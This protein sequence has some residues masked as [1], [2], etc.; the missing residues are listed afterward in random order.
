[1]LYEYGTQLVLSC[2][3]GPD[4]APGKLDLSMA[5]HSTNTGAVISGSF[6]NESDNEWIDLRETLAES[7]AIRVNEAI[8]A[9]VLFG[10]ELRIVG[11]LDTSLGWVQCVLHIRQVDQVLSL[12]LPLR[13]SG[14]SGPGSAE[15][16]R[17]VDTLFDV[18][19][20][21][22]WLQRR[23]VQREVEF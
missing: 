9:L 6:L 10:P 12:D 21:K 17:L 2:F 5:Y 15:L 20:I 8:S 13:L 1:M 19:K 14:F 3:G 18:A 11:N 23:L 7:D 22:H 4:A 16:E